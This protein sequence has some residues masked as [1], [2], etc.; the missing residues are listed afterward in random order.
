MSIWKKLRIANVIFWL[1]MWFS[2][3]MLPFSHGKGNYF[4]EKLKQLVTLNPNL[5]DIQRF[6]GNGIVIIA[7][8]FGLDWVMRNKDK[9]E[10]KG[11]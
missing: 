9:N 11:I 1:W 10:S 3:A 4:A 2:S 7:L 6:I 8:W 5:H